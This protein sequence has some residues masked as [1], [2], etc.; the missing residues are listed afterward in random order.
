MERPGR[1]YEDMRDY[2]RY[3]PSFVITSSAIVDSDTVRP[4]P[5][6]LLLAVLCVALARGVQ[7]QTKSELNTS[8]KLDLFF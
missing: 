6:T 3:G 5:R 1:A 2:R 7:L 8:E 4:M